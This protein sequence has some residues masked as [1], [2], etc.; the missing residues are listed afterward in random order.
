[1]PLSLAHRRERG[2]EA[3]GGF[4]L[5]ELLLVTAIL[6]V[7]AGSAV[8]AM[9][10]T[11]EN[12]RGQIA[13]HEMQQLKQA[14]WQF[15]RDTGNFPAPASPAD[16]S[17]LYAKPTGMAD[18]NIDTGRGWRGPYLS[19]A[20]EGYV[21]VGN[22]LNQDGSGSPLSGSLLENVQGV[23]DPFE[24]PPAA[25]AIGKVFQ[26]HIQPDDE[27]YDRHG[28]PYFLFNLGNGQARIVGMGA[29]GRYEG[30]NGADQC[31]PN[32][33]DLVLCLLR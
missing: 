1:M 27:G 9:G 21:D 18:W 14:L 7:L 29:N 30:V 6:S 17:A 4:T 33:D 20:G 12:A 16:F 22:G 19:R 24:A 23:A 10:D 3:A 5:L 31:A 11:E 32:G 28:R 26:W 2:I 13:R 15:R 8:L 25:E